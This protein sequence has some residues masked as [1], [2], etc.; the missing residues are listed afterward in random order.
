MGES[1]EGLFNTSVM[2]Y[3]SRALGLGR[4]LQLGVTPHA[5]VESGRLEEAKSYLASVGVQI[6]C[7]DPRLRDLKHVA[8][9]SGTGRDVYVTVDVDVLEDSE[10][11]STSYPAPIGLGLR[12]LLA[13]IDA[14]V[15]GN[16][17][18]GFDVVEFAAPREARSARTLAD[19]GRALVI[20]LHLLGHLSAEASI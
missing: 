8:R 7:S 11:R 3:V 15:E 18:V 19:C 9:V 4:L 10:M 20:F 16:R 5:I 13:L 17:L 2:S 1:E 14:V 6:S 12:E